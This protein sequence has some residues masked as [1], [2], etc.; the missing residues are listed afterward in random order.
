MAD[1]RAA[2]K[3]A[4]AQT[5]LRY[6]TPGSVIGVGS[7]S[8]AAAFVDALAAS[9]IEL[10]GAVPSSLETGRLL[11]AAGIRVIEPGMVSRL[12]LYVDGAD[13]ADPLLR[14]IK[15]GGGALT[16]EKIVASMAE[17]FVCIADETKLVPMLG[18]FPLAIEVLRPALPLV[19]EVIRAIGGEPVERPGFV[20]DNGNPILDVSGLDFAEPGSLEHQLETLPGVVACGLFAHRRA[21]VLIV[22]LASGGVRE[23]VPAG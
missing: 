15:G 21:D 17:C 20:S 2:M 4:A 22:G 1:D 18:A 19:A 8:T 5:A 6:V 16:R 23:I 3:E 13:E 12:P 10:D 9:G 11:A 7:G 14:L